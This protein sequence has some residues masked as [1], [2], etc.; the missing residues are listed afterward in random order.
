[1]L[2]LNHGAAQSIYGCGEGIRLHLREQ[3]KTGNEAHL[4]CSVSLK[5]STLLI[6]YKRTSDMNAKRV[7]MFSVTIGLNSYSVTE[8]VI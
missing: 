5:W 2:Y 3:G 4:K 8:S 6:V 1:M 7:E